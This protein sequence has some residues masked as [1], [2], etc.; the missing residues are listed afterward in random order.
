MLG[1]ILGIYHLLFYGVAVSLIATG[2]AIA[3]E[4]RAKS[5]YKFYDEDAENERRRSYNTWMTI[6]IIVLALVLVGYAL[7][8]VI[9]Y[10][11]NPTLHIITMVLVVSGSDI[12][13]VEDNV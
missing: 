13:K 6:T 2:N 3:E 9:K 10:I 7:V 1:V 11:R 4:E 8:V 12:L 5:R